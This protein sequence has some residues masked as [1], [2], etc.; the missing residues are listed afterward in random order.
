MMKRYEDLTFADDFMFCKVLR[1]DPALCRELLELVIGEPVGELVTDEKQ[2]P[3][4]I[5]PDG[6][7]VRFDVY[8]TDDR[9]VIYD[10]EMQNVDRDN[11][12]KRVR[13]S[14]GLIDLDAMER[15]A[16]YSELNKSYVIFICRFNLWENVGLHRYRFRNICVNKPELELN[17][18]A[19]KLFLCTKGTVVDISEDLLRFLRYVADGVIEDD[20]TERLQAA[21]DTA[22]RNQLWRKEFMDWRDHLDDAYHEG[23]TLG[24][25]AGYERGETAGYI[26]A[27]RE[28]ERKECLVRRM[29]ADGRSEELQAALTEQTLLEKLFS[30]YGI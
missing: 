16:H 20:F 2:Y 18:G 29:L 19:E 13:Y 23:Y 1:N 8:A 7:G 28:A 24:E 11:L 4:E 26:R 6:K 15:G 25:A 30:E 5:T 10:V 27:H 14:Q 3:I 17:D 12:P 21:V 22:K 9:T